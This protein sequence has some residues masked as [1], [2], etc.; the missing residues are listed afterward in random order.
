MD[1]E[2]FIKSLSNITDKELNEIIETRGKK[3]LVK[4]FIRLNC[5][6][7]KYNDNN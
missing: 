4:P 6:V 1:K 5:G 2:N 3:K 7:K